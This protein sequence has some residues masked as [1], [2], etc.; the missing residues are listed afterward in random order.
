LH[1]TIAGLK[2]GIIASYINEYNLIINNYISE[3]KKIAVWK[4]TGFFLPKDIQKKE[5]NKTWEIQCY[6]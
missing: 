1:I 4:I 3:E 6:E 5:F 2:E